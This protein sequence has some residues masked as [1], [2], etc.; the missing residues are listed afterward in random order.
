MKVEVEEVSPVQKRVNVELPAEQVDDEIE[1]Q[2][3]EFQDKAQV[4][5][6]RKGKAPRKML[7]RRFGKYVLELV[8][9]K[10]IKSSLTAALDRK[11]I[12][13]VAEP[14]LDP[15][16]VKAGEP[17]AYTL[18]VEVRPELS[19]VKYDGISVT[20]SERKV[21]ESDVDEAIQRMRESVAVIQAPAE[22]RP[23]KADDQLTARVTMKVEGEDQPAVEN[24]EQEI[25]LW[26]ETWIPGL[27]ERLEGRSEG[28]KTSFAFE[29]PDEETTPSQFR[30]KKLELTVEVIGIK[31]RKLP[32]L[33]D[34]FAKEHT[35]SQT[36]AELREDTRKSLEERVKTMNLNALQEA[37]LG[38]L[39]KLN[40][41]EVPPSLA[42]QEAERMANDFI[43]QSSRRTPSQQDLETFSQLFMDDARRSLAASYLLEVVARA[44]QLEVSEEEFEAEIKK[45]AE[46]VGM[47][48]EKLKDRLGETGRV[49]M[50]KE[51]E[52]RKALEF[53][54]ARA[55]IKQEAGNQ[56]DESDKVIK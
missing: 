4:P 13:P 3:K 49:A 1:E 9:E 27:A 7:E 35:R 43:M 53:L 26:R 31:E 36:L 22:P 50:Q 47:N 45:R 51:L 20:H 23:V 30:G 14:V 38:E 8:A 10:L 55:N 18:H 25:E 44:E 19:E 28:D 46:R 32:P 11:G 56:D 21:L 42:R 6:F 2:F 54:V 33:D 41:I 17:Y 34:E 52:F 39:I 40:P 24:Q 16:E 29:A 12:E 48:E 37:V 5:G 15:S